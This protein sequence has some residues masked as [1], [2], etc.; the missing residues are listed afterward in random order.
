M[1]YIVRAMVV[2]AAESARSPLEPEASALAQEIPLKCL[3]N[4]LHILEAGREAYIGP[5]YPDW[6]RSR[7]RVS[8]IFEDDG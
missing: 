2:L 4:I 1:D 6:V 7:R 8:S 3:L 5:R